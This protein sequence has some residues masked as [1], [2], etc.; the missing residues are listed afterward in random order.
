[1][2]FDVSASLLKRAE[3][4]QIIRIIR[5]QKLNAEA[6]VFLVFLV[7]YNQERGCLQTIQLFFLGRLLFDMVQWVWLIYLCSGGR[8]FCF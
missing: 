7:F 5:R 4:I 1:L 2:L 8:R 6:I 3:A